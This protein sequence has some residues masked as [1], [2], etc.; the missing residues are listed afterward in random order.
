M[1]NSEQ[2]PKVGVI[3]GSKSDLSIVTGVFNVF[4]I[5]DVPFEMGIKS[6]HRTPHAMLNYAEEAEGRGLK[7]IIAAAGGSAHLPGMVA[8]STILPVLG[9]P[10]EQGAITGQNE[11]VG[12]MIR[13]PDGAP[14]PLVGQNKA[15]LAGE[16]AIRV[17]ALA[18]PELREKYR[19]AIGD[20]RDKVIADNARLREI[21]DQE[22]LRELEL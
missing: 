12:S 1:T 11:A 10:I 6:A 17:L 22:F 19:D 9:L 14:L 16:F 7:L 8:S 18:D 21:G 5:Y 15:T 20:M 2:T 4:R 3:M 13:M